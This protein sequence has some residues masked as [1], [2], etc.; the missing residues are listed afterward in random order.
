VLPVA[1]SSQT[2][3]RCGA[4]LRGT[5]HAMS[6]CRRDAA[7]SDARVALRPLQQRWK[8]L[9][10]SICGMRAG[11]APTSKPAATTSLPRWE[12]QQIG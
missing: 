6:C 2:C 9:P 4:G 10:R 5:A 11:T 1:C 8:W 12:R 7:C 3:L